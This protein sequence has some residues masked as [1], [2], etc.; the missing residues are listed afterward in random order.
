MQVN[1]QEMVC[2][3]REPYN[4]YDPNAIKVNNVDGDQVGHIKRE[5]A[6]PLSQIMDRGLGRIEG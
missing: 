6:K 4:K 3:C 2:L 1:N 5:L